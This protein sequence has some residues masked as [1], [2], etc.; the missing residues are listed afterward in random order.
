MKFRAVMV[1]LALAACDPQ[2]VIDKAMA[3]TAE[4]VIAPVVGPG[5]ARCIVD[6]GSPAELRAIAAD[7]GVEAGSSTKA[8]IRELALRPGAQACF[9]ARGVPP[10]R[11]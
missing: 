10:L 8:R 2:V 7:I 5:A 11:G 4:T 1:V 6:N 9:A 3:R